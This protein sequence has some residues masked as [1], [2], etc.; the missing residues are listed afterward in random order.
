[1]IIQQMFSTSQL[2]G[3]IDVT[4]TLMIAVTLTVETERNSGN[5][6]LNIIHYLPPQILYKKSET[7]PCWNRNLIS[8]L[9]NP[10]GFLGISRLFY[11]H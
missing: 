10:W 3:T 6:T 8:L 11:L 4:S 7:L 9:L 5:D 2:R 1:M